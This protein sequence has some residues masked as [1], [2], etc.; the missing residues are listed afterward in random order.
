[1]AIRHHHYC[2][3]A[4][5][6][7]LLLSAISLA[8]PRPH[9]VFSCWVPPNVPLHQS[10]TTLFTDAFDSLGYDFSMHYRPN[11]RSLMEAS[12][13]ISDGDCARAQGYV[14]NNP[15]TNLVRVDALLA[16]T[17]V[18]AWSHSPEQTVESE[19]DLLREPLRIGYVRGHV[20]I[21]ELIERLDLP[22]VM[23][24]TSTEH[25]LKMLS[26]GR[27]D[28]FIGTSVS[29]RQELKNIDLANPIYSV[30]H[31]IDIQGYAY[32]NEK[33]RSLLPGL[34]RELRN[35]LPEGGRQFE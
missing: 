21:K 9:I 1:M 8:E 6:G 3:T 35:R 7:W 31:V 20:V 22:R 13:G 34:A 5:L 26:A 11:Q 17:S 16:Q 19:Q 15:E 32:L 4:L 18:E 28:L 12:A 29:T 33:H 23:S 24:V 2:R 10:L 30:G 25:G 27:L 14:D